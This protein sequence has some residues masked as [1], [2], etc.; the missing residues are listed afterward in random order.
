LLVDPVLGKIVQ[1]SG[2]VTSDQD[3]GG[4]LGI[5][6]PGFADGDFFGRE[7][8]QPVRFRPDDPI[9]RGKGMPAPLSFAK[10]R[11]QER[12]EFIVEILTSAGIRFADST[13]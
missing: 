12:H 8:L 11:R 3:L 9:F 1:F 5:Q 2:R 7:K 4:S 6:V 13:T 10:S